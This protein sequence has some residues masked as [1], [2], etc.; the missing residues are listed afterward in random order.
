MGDCHQG[1]KNFGEC[2]AFYCHKILVT[3]IF[4]SSAVWE[5][6][7]RTAQETK[8]KNISI[9]IAQPIRGKMKYMNIE[10]K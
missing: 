3:R 7:K 4:G 5:G 10:R 9:D 2:P 8:R 6:E 1:K